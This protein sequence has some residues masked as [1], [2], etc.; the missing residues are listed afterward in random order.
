[1][2]LYYALFYLFILFILK[3]I[4]NWVHAIILRISMYAKLGKICHEKDFEIIKPRNMFA[5]MF[6]FSSKPDIVIRTDGTE[7]LIRL[8]TCRA[9]KRVYH[10]VNHEWFVR[11]FRY[12]ILT[13]AFHSGTPFTLTKRCKY[14]PPLDEKYISAESDRKHQIVLLFNPSPL[15]ITYTTKTN[16]REIGGNGSFFDGWLIYNANA[17]AKHLLDGDNDK[18]S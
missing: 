1:M 10:F 16:R 18:I 17:F 5:S 6:R 12:Y 4:Y 2:V 8:I 3:G 15:E 7:Y 9:R 13:L 14:L 11:A